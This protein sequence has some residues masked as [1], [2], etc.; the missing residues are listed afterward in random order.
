MRHGEILPVVFSLSMTACFGM[1]GNSSGDEAT[2]ERS[3]FPI[4]PL[5]R[6]AMENPA[7]LDAA[8]R[9]LNPSD[10]EY[11]LFHAHIASQPRY[12]RHQMSGQLMARCYDFALVYHTRTTPPA[13]HWSVFRLCQEHLGNGT[14]AEELTVP[15][16]S[17]AIASGGIECNSPE[18]PPGVAPKQPPPAATAPAATAPAATAPPQ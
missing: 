7:L 18:L 17:I 5:P 2:P 3:R 14:F 6:V 8:I 10:K 11:Q 12:M 15:R 9:G 16:L 1:F 4:R 13:C